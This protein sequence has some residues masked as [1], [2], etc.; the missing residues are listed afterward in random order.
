MVWLQLAACVDMSVELSDAALNF[1]RC[2]I[3][4][5]AAK[6][7]VGAWHTS[8]SEDV[9]SQILCTRHSDCLS[10]SSGCTRLLYLPLGPRTGSGILT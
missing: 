7:Q 10:L 1:I 5:A 2:A 4:G 8:M 6:A 9:G 3:E